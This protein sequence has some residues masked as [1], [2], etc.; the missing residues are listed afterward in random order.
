MNSEF[1]DAIPSAPC[2][3]WSVWYKSLAE[4]LLGLETEA[5]LDIRRRQ[6]VAYLCQFLN[7]DFGFWSWGRGHPETDE[8]IVPVAMIPWGMEPDRIG[9]FFQVGMSQDSERWHRDPFLPLLR[10][11]KQVCKARHH[12]WE[13]ATWR[14]CSFRNSILEHTSLDEWMICV[15]YATPRVWSCLTF[16]RSAGKPPFSDGE[17]SALD[18]IGTS[19]SWLQNHTYPSDQQTSVSGLSRRNLEVLHLLLDGRSR[20]EIASIMGLT[21][22]VVNDCMKQIYSHFGAT[23]ATELAAIFL[24]SA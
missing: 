9:W 3:S 19:V 1:A 24:R 5:N 16:L 7:A 22:H 15:R 10:A 11:Q 23:S 17:C 13:D 2:P 8:L 21:T 18:L 12:F 4:T 20:K 6:A 14:A